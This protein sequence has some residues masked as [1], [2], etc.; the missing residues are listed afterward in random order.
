MTAYLQPGDKIHL[1]IPAARSQELTEELVGIHKEN[2]RAVGVEVLFVTIVHHEQQAKVVSVV[3]QARGA[4][5]PRSAEK[6]KLVDLEN[7]LPNHWS[8]PWQDPA[9]TTEPPRAKEFLPHG[10]PPE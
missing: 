3:R 5:F 6:L 7:D 4:R 8:A 9:E 2:Y 10:F 1:A